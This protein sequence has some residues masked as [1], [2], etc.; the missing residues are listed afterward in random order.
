[1]EGSVEKSLRKEAV[2]AI[3]NGAA[4]FFPDK[5]SRREKLFN[6]MVRLGKEPD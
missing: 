3:L 2:K 1:M 4:I 5:H 6:M